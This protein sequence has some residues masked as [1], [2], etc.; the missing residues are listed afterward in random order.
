MNLRIA[1]MIL[2]GSAALVACDSGNK[3]EADNADKEVAADVKDQKGEADKDKAVVAKA[4]EASAEGEEGCIY[5]DHG[6]EHGDH[7]GK[8]EGCPHGDADSKAAGTGVPGH[9]GAAFALTENK[10]LR[11]VLASAEGALPTTAIQV[12][13][14][15]SS[16]CQKKGCWMV[17]KDGDSAVARILMKDHSFAVPMDVKGKTAIVEGTL[18]SRTFSEKEVKH[19]EKDGG[20]DPAEVTGERKEFVLTASGIKF[21]ANS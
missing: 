10:P 3:Q 11:E 17:L 19:L 8:E 2:F 7:H 18:T 4:D 1:A 16:V 13:G 6:A 14:E 5:G 21:P 12:T 20:G 9:H 15:V